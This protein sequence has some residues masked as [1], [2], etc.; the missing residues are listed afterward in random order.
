MGT[1]PR[2]P[3]VH[4]VIFIYSI[5]YTRSVK[6]DVGISGT[7]SLGKRADM[8]L[9]KLLGAHSSRPEPSVFV[10]YDSVIYLSV[11]SIPDV[12]GFSS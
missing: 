2:F 4:F 7:R 10:T 1:E 11:N 8:G 6:R 5:S 12:I 9:E 3:V